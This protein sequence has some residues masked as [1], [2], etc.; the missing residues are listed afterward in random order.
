MFKRFGNYLLTGTIIALP[1]AVTVF[2]FMFL[3][4]NIGT[5]VSQLIFVPLFQYLD[6]SLPH[7]GVG[8]ILLDIIS[9]VIVLVIITSLGIASKFFLTNWIISTSEKA[10]NKIPGVGLVY[11]TVKQIVDTFSKQNK[12]VF[13]AVVMVEFPRKGMYA[14]GFVTSKAKGE[15]QERTGEVVVNVFIPTTPNP[16]SGFL[17]MVPQE[18]LEY[19]DM[20]V[21]DAMKLIISGGAVVPEYAK[22]TDAHQKIK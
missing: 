22:K 10:I 18:S 6:A 19:L 20:S 16:T 1:I 2:V 9:T 12:A 11:R 5:P 15:I 17:V 4:R 14:V 21:G 8:K 7:S 13:Q 3:I